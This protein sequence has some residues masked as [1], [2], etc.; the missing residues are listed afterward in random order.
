MTTVAIQSAQ[1]PAL[2][3]DAVIRT[4]G[5]RFKDDLHLNDF[6][7]EGE[8]ANIRGNLTT[9]YRCDAAFAAAVAAL[10]TRGGKIRV[11]Y[12][13]YRFNSTIHLKKPIVLECEG[14]GITGNSGTTFLFPINTHGIVF[15]SHNTDSTGIVASGLTAAGTIVTGLTVQGVSGGTSGHGFW[16]RTKVILRDCAAIFFGGNGFHNVTSTVGDATTMG[17]SNNWAMSNCR[18]HNNGGHGLFVDLIDA[19]AGL[20][21]QF[22]G[23]FNGG[24]GIYD[25]SFLGNTYVGCHV[26]SN[27]LGAYKSDDPNACTMFLGCYSEG[28]QPGSFINHPAMLLGGAPGAGFAGGDGTLFFNNYLTSFRTSRAVSGRTIGMEMNKAANTLLAILAAGDAATG[29]Q[30]IWWDETTKTYQVRHATTR[31]PVMYT[32]DISTPL[33]EAGVRIP[34]GNIIFPSSFYVPSTTVP[35]RYKKVALG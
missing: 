21:L 19:N 16:L 14:S 28:G 4:L 25:S 24:W 33:D 32:N 18:G 5:D 10:P 34:G 1:V 9:T 30:A 29:M 35:G 8:H 15:H 27:T 3:T 13:V 20:C 17:N 7:T 26:D 22:D 2:H 23:S 6:I 12:G 11:G 31:V